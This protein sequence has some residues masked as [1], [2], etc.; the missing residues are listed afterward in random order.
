MPSRVRGRVAE[1]K[2]RTVSGEAGELGTRH[3]EVFSATL[4][5]PEQH[6]TKLHSTNPLERLNK[7][8]KRRADVV[9]I[10]PN[11][12]TIIRLIGAVLLDRTERVE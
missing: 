11:E 3:A 9:G 12:A 10:F 6:R 7:E 5:F 1:G 4:D 2:Q 8:V